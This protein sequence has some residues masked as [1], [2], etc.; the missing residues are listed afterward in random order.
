MTLKIVHG[1]GGTLDAGEIS[2]PKT[3][4]KIPVITDFDPTKAKL[5]RKKLVEFFLDG[6]AVVRASAKIGDVEGFVGRD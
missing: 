4:N 1:V 5:A 2:N 3:P 6:L